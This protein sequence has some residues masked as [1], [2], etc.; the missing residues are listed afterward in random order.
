VD[1]VY[2]STS[3]VETDPYACDV[4]GL[5]TLKCPSATGEEEKKTPLRAVTMAG[6]LYSGSLGHWWSGT[7]TGGGF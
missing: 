6:G 2:Q 7:H 5:A 1:N 4:S 3:S